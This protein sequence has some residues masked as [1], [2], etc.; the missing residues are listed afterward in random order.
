MTE[1]LTRSDVVKFFMRNKRNKVVF[2]RSNYFW[3]KNWK[4]TQ[5]NQDP[6]IN[7]ILSCILYAN[8]ELKYNKNGEVFED[9]IEEIKNI[10]HDKN[11]QQSIWSK[12]KIFECLNIS[13]INN[14]FFLFLCMQFYIN[15]IICDVIGIKFY[16]LDNEFDKYIPTLIL[17]SNTN[18]ITKQIYYQ[19]LYNKDDKYLLVGDELNEFID[20]KD[21]FIIGLDKN[22]QFIIKNYSSIEKDDDIIHMEKRRELDLENEQNEE[23]LYNEFEEV[24]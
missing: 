22:K 13:N 2:S 19:V 10:L 5:F 18:D 23:D 8:K 3:E 14:D 24:E 12:K 1:I 7:N 6:L 15:I 17:Q 11:L 4:V 9:C 21:K 20:Y 16:Y